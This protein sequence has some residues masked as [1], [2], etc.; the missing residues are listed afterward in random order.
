[1]ALLFGS[2]KTN[3]YIQ[4]KGKFGGSIYPSCLSELAALQLGFLIC[5]DIV[6]LP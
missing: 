2:I 4:S 6:P 3:I 1:M 5:P